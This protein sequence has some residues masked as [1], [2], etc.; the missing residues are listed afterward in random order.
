MIKTINQISKKR[1]DFH[2][3]IVGDGLLRKKLESYIKLHNL[4]KFITFTGEIIGNKRVRYYQNAD[5]FCAP[6]I[7][8][9]FGITVLEASACGL[10]T[11]GFNN[12]AFK[13]IFKNYP[14]PKL[15]VESKNIKK[16]EKALLTLMDD[17]KMRK[18]IS[19]WCVAES[20][21]YN[22][23]KAARKTEDFY[24]KILRGR[25]TI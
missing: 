13:E 6:Y 1:Q 9:A 20:K 11:V 25:K 12:M 23:E 24:F 17:E 8:E 10:P 7:D 16:L 14:Y 2:L 22:W 3:T 21:K 18:N 19:T 4:H 5:I 15:L